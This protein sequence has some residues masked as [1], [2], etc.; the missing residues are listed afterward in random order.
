MIIL[1][2]CY[3]LGVSSKGVAISEKHSDVKF[4]EES[5]SGIPFNIL[6]K[7]IVQFDNSLYDAMK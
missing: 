5:R 2:L 4:G 3:L 6:M 7:D 1:T